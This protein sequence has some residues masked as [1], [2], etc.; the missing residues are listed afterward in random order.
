MKGVHPTACLLLLVALLGV[1]VAPLC[2]DDV[3]LTS[4][5]LLEIDSGEYALEAD[6]TPALVPALSPPVLPERCLRTRPPV[7]YRTSISRHLRPLWPHFQV[8]V[9][10]YTEI[11]AGYPQ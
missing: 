11:A 2:A 4:A 6:I 3:G 1:Q 10:T 8:S 7:R 5:R 9:N